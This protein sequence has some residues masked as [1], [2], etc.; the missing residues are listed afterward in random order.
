MKW[1]LL[2]VAAFLLTGCDLG[3]DR[4][5]DA[6]GLWDAESR[7]CY[8]R[9]GFEREGCVNEPY[10]HDTSDAAEEVAGDDAND[11]EN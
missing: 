5:A 7:T 3:L 9:N 11:E 4:C 2:A 8:C 6:N 1:V 10:P